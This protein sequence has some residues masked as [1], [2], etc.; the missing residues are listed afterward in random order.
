MA[1]VKIS[2]KLTEKCLTH[3]CDHC[4]HWD[5]PDKDTCNACLNAAFT[6]G[7]RCYFLEKE[8]EVCGV[9]LSKI[10]LPEIAGKELVPGV[11]AITNLTAS[12]VNGKPMFTCLANVFGSLCFVEVNVKLKEDETC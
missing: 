4:Q 11:E 8:V 2:H 6:Q 1:I 3:S 9:P 12:V 7:G 10:D 5:N